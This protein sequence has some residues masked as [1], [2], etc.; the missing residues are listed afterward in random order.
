MGVSNALRKRKGNEMKIAVVYQNIRGDA[1]AYGLVDVPVGHAS[2]KLLAQYANNYL[3]DN[4]LP[5]QIEQ[6]T[7][8][9]VYSYVCTHNVRRMQEA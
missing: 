3:L 6:V 9:A 5:A 7:S 4:A 8:I 1:I 2:E